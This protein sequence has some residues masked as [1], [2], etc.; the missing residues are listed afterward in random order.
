M[1]ETYGIWPRSGEIDLGESRGNDKSYPGGGRNR[2][3]STLHWGTDTDHDAW[4]RSTNDMTKH[5]GDF[6]EDFHTFGVEWS[7]DYLFTWVDDRV[8]KV[9][10]ME[11]GKKFGTM[12]ERGKFSELVDKGYVPENVWENAADWNAPFDEPFYLILNVAVGG[13]TGYFS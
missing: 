3:S 8:T 6:T 2:I 13:T 12:Y 9:L 7:E 4:Y 1:E 10:G 5:R 11:F